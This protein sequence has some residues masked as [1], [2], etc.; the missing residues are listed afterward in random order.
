MDVYEHILQEI[1]GKPQFLIE[2]RRIF[3]NAIYERVV[4]VLTTEQLTSGKVYHRLFE[5][6]KKGKELHLLVN[7][8]KPYKS[9]SLYIHA[10]M[11]LNIPFTVVHN[12]RSSPIGLVLAR[13]APHSMKRD[14]FIKDK[15][16]KFDMSR[17]A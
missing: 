5:E 15:H 1:K 7:G 11:Q 3:L 17:L 6:M 12:K 13:V 4:L 16:F 10:A 2:E 9:Y 14:P 8:S